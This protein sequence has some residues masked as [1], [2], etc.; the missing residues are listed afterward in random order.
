MKQQSRQIWGKNFHRVRHTNWQLAQKF[1]AFEKLEG[2]FDVL[3]R[4]LV[5]VNKADD[6]IL[7]KDI[8]LSPGE[9]SKEICWYTPLF[10]HLVALIWQQCERKFVLLFKCL[11]PSMGHQRC[12][13]KFPNIKNVDYIEGTH[14]LTSLLHNGE[15]HISSWL[16]KQILLQIRGQLLL[17]S[18]NVTTTYCGFHWWILVWGD[19]DVHN[20]TLRQWRDEQGQAYKV[21]NTDGLLKLSGDPHSLV[22][23][24]T[25]NNQRSHVLN[26]K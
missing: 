2:L 25:S 22:T 6:S 20:H 4:L 13:E 17:S 24:S 9:S 14:T 7:V 11:I 3:L 15:G 8:G 21:V 16:V 12:H 1:L 19:A 5:V 10:S 18:N 26:R 23:V